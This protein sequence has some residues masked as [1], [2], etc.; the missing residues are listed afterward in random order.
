MPCNFWI[1]TPDYAGLLREA[2]RLQSSATRR[3]KQGAGKDAR[4]SALVRL[5]KRLA[6]AIAIDFFG[7]PGRDAVD[8]VLAAIE[9]ALRPPSESPAERTISR[10]VVRSACASRDGSTD[11]SVAATDLNRSPGLA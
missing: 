4:A 8:G 7:A 3:R 1:S 11:P 6:D 5:R 9:V 2:R 10:D